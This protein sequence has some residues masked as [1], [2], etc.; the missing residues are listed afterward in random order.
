[1]TSEKLGSEKCCRT[2]GFESA[3]GLS[4]QLSQIGGIQQVSKRASVSPNKDYRYL[5]I[6]PIWTIYC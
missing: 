1:M 4:V 2:G 5:C 6:I 3:S